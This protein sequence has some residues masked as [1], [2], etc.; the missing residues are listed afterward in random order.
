M[1]RKVV[2]LFIAVFLIILIVL[3]SIW[4]IEKYENSKKCNYDDPAKTYIKKDRNCIINFLCIQSRVA[5]SDECGCGC[6]IIG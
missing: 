1:T 4:A 3:A 5:F 6:K 2:Y